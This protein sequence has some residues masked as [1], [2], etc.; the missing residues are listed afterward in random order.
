MGTDIRRRIEA[1]ESRRQHQR[2]I[3]GM[4][5]DEIDREIAGLERRLR[6]PAGVSIAA[7][8]AEIARMER[9]AQ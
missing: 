9:G 1:L 7:I 5:L 3:R 6:L 2:E 4:T 8:D